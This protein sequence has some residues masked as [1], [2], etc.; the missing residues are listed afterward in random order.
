MLLSI[1]V[2]RQITDFNPATDFDGTVTVTL[3][4]INGKEELAGEQHCC[5]VT[6][7][8]DEDGVYWKNADKFQF[9]FRLFHTFFVLLFC[10]EKLIF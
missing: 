10:D 4:G 5:Q 6:G 7:R 1:T 3:L 2:V 8:C 9:R